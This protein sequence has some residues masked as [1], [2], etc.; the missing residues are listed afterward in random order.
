[1]R[2]T[3]SLTS[4]LLGMAAISGV[5]APPLLLEKEEVER[6]QDPPMFIFRNEA[7]AAIISQHG[8]FTSYQVNV[9]GNGQNITQDAANEPS[10]AMDPTNRNK[11]SI[12]WRQFDNVSSNFRKAGYGYTSDG[13][14]SWTFPGVLS[15][16]FRSD[17]VLAPDAA[18]SFFYCS[19]MGTLY[20]DIWR[21]LTGGQSWTFL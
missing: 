15:N 10:I 18:G 17:P 16:N 7:S 11:M 6:L 8:A 2:C 5:A 21:S 3:I 13:G 20:T 14:A 9:D 12:G 1:M 19:L 4:I